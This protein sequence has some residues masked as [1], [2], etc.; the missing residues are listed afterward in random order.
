MDYKSKKIVYLGTP[1]ISSI[2]L[3]EMIKEGYNIHLVVTQKDNKV[4]RKQIL[5]ESK[6]SQV[7]KKY[8]IDVFKPEKLNREYEMIEKLKPDLLLTFAYGQILSSKVLSL[9]TYKPINFHASLLPKYRGASPIV[10]V[11]LNGEKKTRR[12]IM[13]M[14]K[15]MD[16]GKVYAQ[17]SIDIEDDDNYTSLEKKLS[18]LSISMMKKYLPLYLENKLEG[19]IQNE[20]EA[21]FCSLIKKEDE[22]LSLNSTANEFANKV[23]AFS[24]YPG[25]YLF[26][27]DEYLKIYK[28]S[29]L[30]DQIIEKTGTLFIKDKKLCLQLKDGI[31][32]LEML[33]RQGKKILPASDFIN[34]IKDISSIDLR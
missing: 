33:Q 14:E 10:S 16:S 4:G 22:H 23:K 27:R 32:S 17:E 15:K 1:E 8:N 5:C 9:G 3:E 24:S 11:L 26:N 21:S 13:E 28:C 31:I 25:A 18:S 30:S 6:V 7:A 2:L 29:I 12:T 19:V 34:G 20:D